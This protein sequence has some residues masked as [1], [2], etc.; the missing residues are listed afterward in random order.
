[1]QKSKESTMRIS[2]FRELQIPNIYTCEAS[3]CGSS[4]GTNEGNHFTKKQLMEIGRDICLS[5]I[6]YYDLD[7]PTLSTS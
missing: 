3:F 5:L 2:L 4:Y 6:I 1:M 7:I